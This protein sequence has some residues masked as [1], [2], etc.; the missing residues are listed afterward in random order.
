M[1]QSLQE[2][3]VGLADTSDL[4]AASLLAGETAGEFRCTEQEHYDDIKRAEG[5]PSSWAVP[6]SSEGT[7]GSCMA[8]TTAQRRPKMQL[9]KNQPAPFHRSKLLSVGNISLKFQF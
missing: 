7:H 1:S 9:R 2:T 3:H 6:S 8:V 4:T 5:Q